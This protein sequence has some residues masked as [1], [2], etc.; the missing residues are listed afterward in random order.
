MSNDAAAR[1][2]LTQSAPPSAIYVGPDAA[3][4]LSAY[5]SLATV[6]LALEGRLIG[7][8]GI[9]QTVRAEIAPSNDRLV[10]TVIAGIA[11]GWLLGGH[12]R[13][14][15]T[16]PRSGQVYARVEVIRGRSGDV[17]PIQLL[18]QGYV[19]EH[20]WLAWPGGMFRESSQ[21]RGVLRVI[22]GTDPAAGAE[23]VETVPTNALWRLISMA[24]TLQTDATVGT[25]APAFIASHGGSTY[26]HAGGGVTTAASAGAR[27]T[28]A[29]GVGVMGSTQN[30]NLV[31]LPADLVLPGGST[32]GTNTGGIF[33]GDN[34]GNPTYLVEEWIGG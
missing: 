14:I 31:A 10:N 34:W 4:R 27:Y 18:A 21:G 26:F 2:A 24:A 8:D 9:V 16:T 25:R 7:L 12:V 17:Q 23:I 29:A 6:R 11:E 5:S 3:L 32:F 1:G 20:S 33:A 13:A 30:G 28:F 19:S 15:V 22:A